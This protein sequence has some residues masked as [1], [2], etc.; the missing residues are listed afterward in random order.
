MQ[1]GIKRIRV[2]III[3]QCISYFSG[4]S[5]SYGGDSEDSDW[6][7]PPVVPAGGGT[8]DDDEDIDE[9]VSEAKDFISNK[10]TRK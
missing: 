2:P 6:A 4:S 8:A 5:S 1:N 9:L 10:K 7:P 3:L